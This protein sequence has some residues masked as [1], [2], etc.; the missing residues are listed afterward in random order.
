MALNWAVRIFHSSLIG[1]TLIKL[2]VSRL[3]EFLGLGLWVGF[4]TTQP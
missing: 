4:V 3:I 2:K 1:L